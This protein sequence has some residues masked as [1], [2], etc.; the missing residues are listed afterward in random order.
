MAEILSSIDWKN[1]KGADIEADIE[2]ET[3]LKIRLVAVDK[4]IPISQ[5]RRRK[6]T[7][8]YDKGNNKINKQKGEAI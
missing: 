1:F 8:I 7:I 4:F 3:V 5:H 6:E 2:A